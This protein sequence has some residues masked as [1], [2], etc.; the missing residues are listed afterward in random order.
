MP[1]PNV[2]IKS[3]TNV[4]KIEAVFAQRKKLYDEIV[5]DDVKS[6]FSFIAS[7]KGNIDARDFLNLS[8]AF[9]FSNP[10]MDDDEYKAKLNE[11]IS[12]FSPDFPEDEMKKFRDEVVELVTKTYET[13]MAES[14]TA[15]E[16]AEAYKKEHGED[17]RYFDMVKDA[18]KGHLINWWLDC[19]RDLT[20]KPANFMNIARAIS[21]NHIEGTRIG[22][23]SKI[24]FKLIEPKVTKYLD[25]LDNFKKFM[26]E[27]INKLDK[28]DFKDNYKCA[29]F[30]MLTQTIATKGDEFKDYYKS[31]VPT[32]DVNTE[33]ENLHVKTEPYQYEITKDLLSCRFDANKYSELSLG[34]SY[35]INNEA[36]EAIAPWYNKQKLILQYSLVTK[37]KIDFRLHESTY[38]MQLLA[39]RY[40]EKLKAEDE[41]DNPLNRQ[42]E[43]NY[44]NTLRDTLINQLEACS[45]SETS[46]ERTSQYLGL[47]NY[48]KFFIDGVQ[49][50]NIEPLKTYLATTEIVNPRTVMYASASIMLNAIIEGN[51][52]IN[53]VRFKEFKNRMDYEIVPVEFKHN[54][55]GY[56]ASKTGWSKFKAYFT[57]VDKKFDA[58][59]VTDEATIRSYKKQIRMAMGAYCDMFAERKNNELREKDNELEKNL[60]NDLNKSFIKENEEEFIINTNS[61]NL[62]N[63]NN[64]IED[65]E[66][67]IV[68]E[69]A[70]ELNKDK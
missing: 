43:D 62:E 56:V 37:G 55:K 46:D 54:K 14:S 58:L 2:Y 34:S 4:D 64:F 48:E 1:R 28:Y 32:A 61:K 16:K 53:Y 33:L 59:K 8:Y 9:N 17:D 24:A 18:D 65:D 15:L 63:N 22:E 31:K 60:N 27:N 49:V 5:T 25:F 38:K 47:M 42:E 29:V 21:K 45:L 51:H 67:N 6:G 10:E 36:H 20:E 44:E 69:N 39:N 30:C 12:A 40:L 26:V 50:K 35:E 52:S 68:N 23:Y 19:K 13:K 7:G 70:L 41:R 57:N 66:Y 11:M 3:R